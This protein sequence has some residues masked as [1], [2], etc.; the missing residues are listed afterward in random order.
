M[1]KIV[2]GIALTGLVIS[3]KKIQA[4]SNKGVI[5]MEQGAE[6]YSDIEIGSNPDAFKAAE[7]EAS[8]A[9]KD[10]AATVEIKETNIKADTVKA[11]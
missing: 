7:T 5:K 4:G 2:L 10:S 1:K 8:G 11:K 9:V 3:C 6:R